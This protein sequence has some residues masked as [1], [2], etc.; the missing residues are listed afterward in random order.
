MDNFRVKATDSIEAMVDVTK[1]ELG[2]ESISDAIFACFL[3][4]QPILNSDRIT[5][6]DMWVSYL[7]YL[8]D[9]NFKESFAFL[10]ERDCINKIIDRVPYSN[11]ETAKR[12]EQIRQHAL[13]FI[14]N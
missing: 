10:I 11:Q 7:G 13:Q 9:M 12:M 8:F 1:E 5:H 14:T 2:A 4:S 3:N 6:M